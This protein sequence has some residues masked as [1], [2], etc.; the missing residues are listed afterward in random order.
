[1]NHR[2]VLLATATDAL[3][4]RISDI[5]IRRDGALALLNAGKDLMWTGYSPQAEL[6]KGLIVA[7]DGSGRAVD[8]VAGCLPKFYNHGESVENDR[9]FEQAMAAP[10]AVIWFT[11]KADGSNGRAYWNPGTRRVE[12]A[13][14]GMLQYAS[15]ENGFTDFAALMREIAVAKYP[16]L[17]DSDLVRRY[18]MIFE[19]IHPS[20]RILTDYGATRDLP[21]IAVIDLSDGHELS[22]LDLEAF[23]VA[24]GLLAIRRYEPEARTFGAALDELRLAWAGTDIEGTVISVESPVSAVPFRLKVKA[25]RYLWLNRL[26]RFCTLK[27][28][29]ELVETL[30]LTTWPALR[31]HLQREDPDL[32]EEVRMGY[33]AHFA[34]WRTWEDV[35]ERA[36]DAIIAAYGALPTLDADQKQFALSIAADPRRAS[37]FDLRR[38]GIDIA[39]PKVL[40]SVR[41]ARLDELRGLD[42]GSD[43]GAAA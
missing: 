20:N 18:T 28:T 15:G 1:V 39:R 43:E 5:N 14:R 35:N 12:F 19:L 13:T 10:G 34:T 25:E 40:A 16:A 37:F 41:D 30:G 38:H 2:D 17:L 29:R 31:S 8:L 3:A 23:C 9:A 27:R 32:P 21:I 26:R 11:L 22:R 42:D 33:E 36:V 24:H 7:V 6:L 4:G